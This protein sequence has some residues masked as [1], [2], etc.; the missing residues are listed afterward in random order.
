MGLLN[1]L[2][3]IL[4]GTSSNKN[5][6]IFFQLYQ[7]HYGEPRCL[8]IDSALEQMNPDTELLC[9]TLKEYLFVESKQKSIMECLVLAYCTLPQNQDMRQAIEIKHSRALEPLPLRQDSPDTVAQLLESIN[10]YIA[11]Q[12]QAI[13]RKIRENNISGALMI[14]HFYLAYQQFSHQEYGTEN[15]P[16]I[17]LIHAAAAIDAPEIVDAFLAREPNLIEYCTPG[18]QKTP[19][20]VATEC[21]ALASMQKLYERGANINLLIK[22]R[23]ISREKISLVTLAVFALQR[24]HDYTQANRERTA[25]TFYEHEEEPPNMSPTIEW[26]FKHGALEIGLKTCPETTARFLA[27]RILDNDRGPNNCYVAI[28]QTQPNKEQLM[29]YLITLAWEQIH[30]HKNNQVA[31]QINRACLTLQTAPVAALMEPTFLHEFIG[32]KTGIPIGTPKTIN[33]LLTT[34]STL[35]KPAEEKVN[36]TYSPTYGR[37]GN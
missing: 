10:C 4:L 34:L 5:L 7:F 15:E 14:D 33:K 13:S 18:G 11:Q 20:A 9:Q 8:G 1:N 29:H 21:E 36:C 17:A 35:P 27:Q 16:K 31:E 28:T 3:S 22:D 23:S 6:L 19:L 24:R 2:R 37:R 26:L 32:H 25:E 12:T 30:K